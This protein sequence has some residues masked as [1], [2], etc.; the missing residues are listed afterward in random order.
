VQDGGLELVRPE[1]QRR[2]SVLSAALAG[3]PPLCL[4]SRHPILVLNG[5]DFLRGASI[6]VP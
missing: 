2:P 5:A 6:G 4:V 1:Q 3:R